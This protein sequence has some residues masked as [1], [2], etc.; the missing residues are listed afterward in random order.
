MGTCNVPVYFNE[1]EVVFILF[2][3]PFWGLSL[4]DCSC[5]NAQESDPFLSRTVSFRNEHTENTKRDFRKHPANNDV[6]TKG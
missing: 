6:T 5:L 3:L 4:G 2:F 1:K